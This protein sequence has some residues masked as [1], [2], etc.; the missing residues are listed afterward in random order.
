MIDRRARFL[1]RDPVSITELESS[2]SVDAVP[3]EFSRVEMTGSLA[4]E[5]TV[6]VGPRAPPKHSDA[7]NDRKV[8]AE[9]SGY[10][11]FT[12]LKWSD[13]DDTSEILL[14]EGW[15]PTSRV[16]SMVDDWSRNRVVRVAGVVRTGETQPPYTTLD[17]DIGRRRFFWIDMERMSDLAKIKRSRTYY[18]SALEIEGDDARVE[19]NKMA[20]VPVRKPLDAHMDFYVSPWHH[21][22]YAATWFTLSAATLL[23][24]AV[25]LRR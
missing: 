23:M 21:V 24:A 4:R 11:V 1:E 20:A 19:K 9:K 15:L 2:E 5:R 8:S 12:P 3:V 10:Y 6:F 7:F 17:P 14:C 25:K 18:V 22:G 13:D 16:N